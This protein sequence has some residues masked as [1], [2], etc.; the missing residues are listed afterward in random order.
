M[1][2]GRRGV[3]G[4]SN[5]CVEVGS[6]GGKKGALLVFQRTLNNITL[7]DRPLLSSF[8]R[9]LTTK[10]SRGSRPSL[11]WQLN[12]NQEQGGPLGGGR[13]RRGGGPVSMMEFTP[14]HCVSRPSYSAQTSAS[15]HKQAYAEFTDHVMEIIPDERMFTHFS[16]RQKKIIKIPDYTS[17][18]ICKTHPI[19]MFLY[20]FVQY[21]T[22]WILSVVVAMYS[23]CIICLP[24]FQYFSLFSIHYTPSSSLCFRG[25]DSGVMSRRGLA[26][27]TSP[28]TANTTVI[29]CFPPRSTG[30]V[31]GK[32]RRGTRVE[33]KQRAVCLSASV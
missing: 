7:R 12:V 31:P 30:V 26:K 33:E 19:L 28:S 8:S 32:R 20:M 5:T 16:R 15:K 25:S 3:W 4:G 21:G 23:M 18:N 17:K 9:N 14:P 29:A 6:D 2:P 22:L 13:G 1:A 11:P 27:V 10:S 24:V